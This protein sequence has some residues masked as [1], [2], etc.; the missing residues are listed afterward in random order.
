[1]ITA[2]KSMK[3][4]LFCPNYKTVAIPIHILNTIKTSCR[5]TVFRVL[6]KLILLSKL[7]IFPWA[8]FFLLF[9]SYRFSP[10]TIYYLFFLFIPYLSFSLFFVLRAH[11]LSSVASL[12]LSLSCLYLC[13]LLSLVS[14]SFHTIH[15]IYI[16]WY[17]S[18]MGAQT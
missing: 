13:L 1:M 6:L 16:R 14:Y 9:F 12:S 2:E 5:C 8:F 10:Y 17:S 11:P 4:K 18:E 15:G 3:F 7:Y